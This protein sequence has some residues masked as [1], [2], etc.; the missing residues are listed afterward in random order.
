MSAR[1]K[2][3]LAAAV[4]AGSALALVIV[5]QFIKPLD[6]QILSASHIEYY[7]KCALWDGGSRFFEFRLPYWHSM[8]VFVSHRNADFGGNRDYQEIR[9]GP[10]EKS[11]RDLTLE[12]GSVLE[13]KLVALLRTAKVKSGRGRNLSNRVWAPTPDDLKWIIER[14]QDRKSAW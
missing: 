9:L 8:V 4:F 6:R 14:I 5:W 3:G 1:A 7:G 2:R 12:P 13:T 11:M 10:S